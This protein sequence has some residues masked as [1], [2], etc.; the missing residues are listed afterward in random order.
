MESTLTATLAAFGAVCLLGFG[1]RFVLR[2]LSLASIRGYP[3]KPAKAGWAVITGASDGIGR[4]FALQLAKKGFNTFLLA[5]SVD[6]LD[7]VKDECEGLGVDCIAYPFDFSSPS[8]VA[9]KKLGRELDALEIGVLVNNVGVSHDFPVSFLDEDM[10]RNELIM[11]VN[12]QAMLKM[13]KLVMPQMV[14]RHHGL[15]LNIGSMLGKVPNALLSVYSASKAF[16][17]HWSQSVAAEVSRQGVHVEHINLLFVQTA[18][19]KIRKASLMTP[20]PKTFVQAVLR[21]C[22]QSHDST[23]YGPQAWVD[24]VVDY[25]PK[26]FLISQISA[27]HA[28]IRKRALRKQE[29]EAQAAKKGK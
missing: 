3:F 9:W 19:S 23:P 27:M 10:A 14:E 22:G 11:A 13:T 25:I 8:P 18:M 6:K 20:T 17:R 26:R 28:D 2:L 16:V 7:G 4:E 1:L 29:R 12:C 5:R 21:N 15:V 24:F